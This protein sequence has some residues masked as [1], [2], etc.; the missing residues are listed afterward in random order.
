MRNET[1][2][3]APPGSALADLGVVLEV[4]MDDLGE[5]LGLVF[6]VVFL[7]GFACR[8]GRQCPMLRSRKR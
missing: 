4:V 3:L 8:P 1:E 7:K 2:G 5:A 6:G